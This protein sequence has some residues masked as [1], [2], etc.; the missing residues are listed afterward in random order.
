MAQKQTHLN[1]SLIDLIVIALG[2]AIYSFGIVFFNIYNHLADGGVTGIT[3][4]LRAL[5]H[6]DPAYSTILVNIPL[7]IIGYR[8]LG[9]KDM[10]YTLYGTIVLAVFL[11]I[12]QRV[13]LVI[14][15]DHDLLLSAIGAGLFGGFGCG[16]VYRFGGTTGGVDIVA[17][18]FER[19]K[20]IQMGQT[21]LTIDVIVLLSSLIYLDVRQMAYTL[22]YVWIFSVIVNFTQQGAYTAR[23]ILII[24]N[25]SNAISTAIQSELSRGVTFLNAEGGYSHH[26]KQI[27]YCVVS[28]SELHSLKQ[29]VESIDKEA[30]ISILDV[31]EAI[32]E[33]FTYKRPKK[34]K[35]L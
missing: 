18:L 34:F 20:G 17:R 27:I 14:N 13:P 2:T 16:I 5:F 7:F 22:I 23:G 31:N 3:L 9:K 32:G 10:F 30:F 4:I 35:I 15:I 19:F 28:P 29:L 25:E 6:I 33:G 1:I 26:P 11:W 12:W 21:L 8:F 24:S